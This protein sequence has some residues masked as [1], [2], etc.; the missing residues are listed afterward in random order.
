MNRSQKTCLKQE[1]SVDELTHPHNGDYVVRFRGAFMYLDRIGY[2]QRPSEIC[3]LKWTGDFDNWEFA[4]YKH[5]RNYYDLDEWF[6]PGAGEVDGTI[7]GAMRA[8]IIAYPD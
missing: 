7:L 6:F 3:R 1:N 4:I 2:N 8:G 5:S